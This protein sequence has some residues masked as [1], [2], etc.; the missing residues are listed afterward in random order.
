MPV[1]RRRLLAS[2]SL[3]LGVLALAHLPMTANANPQGGQIIAG[4]ASISSTSPSTLTVN[5]QSEKGIINWTSFN[6]A[7]GETTRFI[8][9]NSGSVTLNRVTG[10]DPS[11]I[12]GNL[13]ANGQVWL[14]NPEGIVFGKSARVN[15]GGLLATTLDIANQDFMAGNY[16]FAQTGAPPASVVNAGNITIRSA[17]LAALVAPGVAN[18]GVITARLGEIQLASATG[19]TVDFYGDGKFNFLLSQPVSD[20]VAAGQGA[21]VSNSGSLIADGGSVYLTANAAKSVVDHAINMSGF[22]EARTVGTQGGVIT[23]YGGEG[24]VAVSGSID[25]TGASAGQGGGAV[26]ITGQ[27][28]SLSPTAQI[29]A[30]GYG[31]GGS[32]FIGGDLHGAGPLTDAATTEIDAGAVIKADAR[33]SGAGG[34]VVVWS[35]DQTTFAGAISAQGGSQGG[36]GGSVEVSSHR[37][38]NFTGVVDLLGPMGTAGT[39]LLDPE[40]VTIALAGE[41]RTPPSGGSITLNPTAKN[42][43][44]AVSTLEQA[45]ALA[46][47]TVTTGSG[48]SQAGDITV[49]TNVSWSSDNSLTLSAY[50]NVLVKDGVTIANT[51][52]GNLVLYADST[53]T[54]V[55][56]V[57]FFG[58]GKVDFSQSTGSVSIYYNPASNPAGSV[59]NSNSYTVSTDFTGSVITNPN[60]AIQLNAYMLVN[61]VYD[62]QN[63]SN[64]LPGDYA[65]GRNIDAS[66]T[67]SWNGG[68]GFE[69]IGRGSM[70]T[71]NLDGQNYVID[72]LNINSTDKSVGMFSTIGASSTVGNIALTNVSVQGSE[73][74]GV[75]AQLNI[76]ALAGV[77]YGTVRNASVSGIV[78]A[79]VSGGSAGVI[80]TGGLIGT[81]AGNIDTAS[82]SAAVT[83]VFSN[84]TAGS[85]TVSVGGL[86]GTSTGNISNS[87]ASGPVTG[88]DQVSI[89]GLVGIFNPMNNGYQISGSRASGQVK[90]GI[91]SA[92]GGLAGTAAAS[93][94]YPDYASQPTIYNSSATGAVNGASYANVGGLIGYM[95]NINVSHSFA[96]GN[97][98]DINSSNITA[99]VGGLI[100]FG[101][102][103][104]AVASF[105]TGNVYAGANTKTGG[106][107]GWND[108]NRIYD[109]YA[110]GNV[111]AGVNSDVGGL[112]G[113]SIESII[114]QSYATGSI[115]AGLGSLSGGLI[116]AADTSCCNNAYAGDVTKS[117]WATDKSGIN[118]GVGNFSPSGLTGAT[119]DKLTAGLPV[120]FDPIVW[121]ISAMV[122]GG[123]PYLN[124]N[125]PG[126]TATPTPTPAP[127]NIVSFG[128]AQNP[129]QAN[130]IQLLASNLKNEIQAQFTLTGAEGTLIDN[131]SSFIVSS[132]SYV[133]KNPET[134]KQYEKLIIQAVN[135]NITSDMVEDAAGGLTVGILSG[136]ISSAAADCVAQSLVSEGVPANSTRI[137][138]AKYFTQLA[139]ASGVGLITG[140]PGGA[141]EQAAQTSLSIVLS[142][143][144]QTGVST[145]SNL[146]EI[147]KDI[148]IQLMDQINLI[149][150]IIN[151]PGSINNT[152]NEERLNNSIIILNADYQSRQNIL[153][154]PLSYI[155]GG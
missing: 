59:V 15:V 101:Q 73:Q 2:S 76:G 58:T 111:S 6:I 36:N 141:I 153:G 110:T 123:L 93:T 22:V 121:A 119:I 81:N 72:Q 125:P 114:D 64:N 9:P 96:T 21:A 26:S 92:V 144:I 66:A 28:V 29:N 147:D 20:A 51:G 67:E 132:L 150:Y 79:P 44:I 19:F 33:S 90:G 148:N 86:V 84:I 87:S 27:A 12:L 152:L 25:A 108:E 55:G 88:G 80:G 94:Y 104:S 35:D 16:R 56:T 50:R 82:S 115:S 155:F 109:V 126:G 139:I 60:S 130:E 74:T 18:S 43:V 17:G 34:N 134:L 129:T 75:D 70:F 47:V 42:S 149:N 13:T 105:A 65:V 95:Y 97:V 135:K 23:L 46:S 138:E 5:Q 99:S 7:P 40:N 154:G 112:I 3:G 120:G 146:Q 127:V 14:I 63:I 31:G 61:T 140:G 41:T 91:N 78:T 102:G 103:G 54:G 77:N 106:L 124:A 38:L 52:A 98:T 10:G 136:I 4:Q 48:G 107:L 71:G 145:Y 151:N 62:L 53:G 30:S 8:Q 32:I 49:A 85:N 142:T 45:L 24:S 69:P 100:G 131:A 89:G 128:T 118:I 1:F 143:A 57:A 37:L 122:N 68:A 137:V 113:F 83:G 39:L 116:G 11:Q 133:I 117:Y